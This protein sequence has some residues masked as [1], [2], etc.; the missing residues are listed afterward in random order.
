VTR[1]IQIKDWS[2]TGIVKKLPVESDQMRSDLLNPR[3][4]NSPKA[5]LQLL[6]A[7]PTDFRMRVQAPRYSLVVSSQP[8]WPGWK[9][10]ANGREV[11]PLM[12]NGAFI[13]FT[14]RP[15]TTDV[16]VYYD[17]WTFKLGVGLFVGTIIVLV[18]LATWRRFQPAKRR[19]GVALD[20]SVLCHF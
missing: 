20:H 11:E 13:G 17:P 15:G 2:F 18:G 5:T 12:A 1:L 16:R 7:D 4:A 10:V 14:V 3:P 6:K 9:V 8:W 19:G